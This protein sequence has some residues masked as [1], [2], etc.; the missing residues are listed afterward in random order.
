MANDYSVLG[1]SNPSTTARIPA[2]AAPSMLMNETPLVVVPR[3]SAMSS[4][5]LMP[6]FSPVAMG[7]LPVSTGKFAS[8]RSSLATIPTTE[9]SSTA[10]GGLSPQLT[11]I[12]K[13]A[14]AKKDTPKATETASLESLRVAI[15]ELKE[16][17]LADK[18][19]KSA[20]K[21]EKISK[22]NTTKNPEKL[23]SRTPVPTALDA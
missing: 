7:N 18:K 17:V 23:I 3:S 20:T 6:A 2:T 21:G 10:T 11:E 4:G 12:L 9:G 15:R 19:T 8:P 5:N 22:S 13:T 14:L 1:A 16:E